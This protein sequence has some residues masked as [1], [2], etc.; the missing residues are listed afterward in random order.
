MT[1]RRPSARRPGPPATFPLWE[2]A[3][4]ILVVLFGAL[5]FL[6][7]ERDIAGL[8][9]FPLDDSWIYATFARNLATGHGYAFN[10]GESIAGA[11][12]PL[13]VFILAL[14]Y[15]I[16]HDVVWPAK[17]LGILCLAVSSLVIHQT[18]RRMLPGHRLAPFLA[19]LLVALSP[20]LL[21]GSLTGLEL[22]VYLLLACIGVSLYVREKWTLAVLVWAIGVWLRPDGLLLVL[23]GL[24]LRPRISLK[25][26]MAPL[27]AAAAVVGAYFGFN[28]LVGGHLL[29]NSVGVKAHAGSNLGASEWVML[30]HWAELWGLPGKGR[31]GLHAPILLAGMAAGAVAS[32]RRWP[33]LA[34]YALLFPFAFAAFGSSPGQFDRYIA[35]V[36]PFGVL[37]AVVGLDRVARR[38]LPQRALATVMI[39]GVVCVGWEAYASRIAG[40]GYGWNVQNIN[41][42][43]RYIAEDAHKAAAPGDTIAVNDVGAMGYFS[44]CYVVDL[45]GLVSPRREFPEN[46]RFY[47]PK[48]MA[49]F[50]DWYQKFG[51]VDRSTGQVV[52]YGADSTYKYAPFVGI[53]LRN[54]TIS[55]RNTMYVYR[56]M[57]RDEA[58]AP[59][60]PIV[61]Q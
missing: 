17:V 20:T 27:A 35:Y 15:R 43:Q 19:G 51:I 12:G 54:N 7:A 53:R 18:A 44:G 28:Q 37:L 47:R 4:L 13:Y 30:Q 1:P 26:S 9:G 56:R 14:F 48:F 6:S 33:A 40:I 23:M 22:P 52:F 38:A 10:P 31:V 21:W 41:G 50:P 5:W 16:F 2:S 57:R 60:V 46:L 61:E 42:M 59:R 24:L 25:N 29:P 45:V 55:A 8:R 3:A 39:L 58:S 34:A 36:V 32:F 11:T 49:I